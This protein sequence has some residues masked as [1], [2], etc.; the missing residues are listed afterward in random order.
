M[1]NPLDNPAMKRTSDWILSQE[2]P[3]D[4]TIQVGDATF[5]L[6]KLRLASRCDY[7]RKQV[8][9]INGSRVTHIDITGVPGGARAFE[10][11][12]K[13][14]YGENLEITEDNVAMLRC[15]AEHLEMT[16]ESKGASLVG[17]T[18][19]YLEAVALTSLAGAVAV[20]RKSEEL[21]PVAEEVDL[22]GRSIDAIAHITCNDSQF[23]MSLGRTAGSY[24]GVNVWKA[25]DDW[26]ADELTS[27]RID[28]FQRV[29]MA[30]KARGFK[31]IALGTL[32][33]LYAQKSLRRLNVHGR[34]KKMDPRQEHEKR[35]VLETIVSLLPKEKNS[36]S[37]SF[38][39][40]LLRAA[41]HL[42]TTLACRLDLE[43][44][45]AAQLGQAVLDDLL[46][47]SS[48]ADAGTMFDVDA[49]QRI[50][51]GY[52][53]HEGEATRLDYSTDDDFISTASPVNDVGMVGKLME[54]YLAEIAS[55]VKLTIDKFTGL[56]EM[57]PERAR[58]NEDGMYRAID[59]YLKAHPHLSEAERRKVCKAMDCQRLSREACAHAAQNDRLP[60]QTVVQVLYHEQR[61][62]R[63]APTHPPSGA[64]SFSGESPAPSLA[65]KPT[66]SL[67]GRHARGGAAQDELSRLQRENEE[68]KMEV[69]RLKMRLRDLSALPPAGGAPPP[70][71]RPP[72]PKK[73]AGGGF[74][75]NVSKKL[76]RLN[77]FLRHDAMGG[78]K[79]RAKPPKDRR[80]SIGW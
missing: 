17:T 16:D 66:R 35:V 60:V 64:S 49:V 73:A 54:A 55:D 28:T 56:A 63:E 39:S 32:I 26:L 20:L 6:H 41:L 51:A 24:N 74:M 57:I 59:I 61:R 13:F 15:A 31:G 33:M 25:V 40:M 21:I 50:L 11:V 52:L 36:M 62:L 2:F 4:I 37:V 23:T 80:H 22:V 10:L 78:E 47:P 65:Y 48:S 3:S 67:M 30:M 43:K 72:P 71:G 75:N 53:E 44:R 7:I 79:V 69:M 34:D 19:A 27:L 38:L 12:T 45:I 29:V 14:C 8:S 18:E 76:G 68:L 58:F 46:I 77:P 1:E 70:S 5:N 9:G 42:D